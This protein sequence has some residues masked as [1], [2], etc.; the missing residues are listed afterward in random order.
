MV[1]ESTNR[2]S[3]DILGSVVVSWKW[4]IFLPFPF[5]CT[6]VYIYKNVYETMFTS[7]VYIVLVPSITLSTHICVT[8][9]TLLSQALQR[10]CLRGICISCTGA[11]GVASER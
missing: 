5:T 7:A 1:E 9:P 11:G 6:C 2:H 3:M 10:L 8:K 4:K